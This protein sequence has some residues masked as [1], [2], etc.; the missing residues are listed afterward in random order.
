MVAIIRE[1]KTRKYKIYWYE[2]HNPGN[3]ADRQEGDI[4]EEGIKNIMSD[5][6]PESKWNYDGDDGWIE[7]QAVDTF[8]ARDIIEAK[9][10]A[11][12]Y[13]CGE[14]NIFTVYDEYGNRLFTEEDLER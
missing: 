9:K 11:M 12:G 8:E 5:F 2:Y 7:V 10:K 6:S 1:R 13:E 3:W 4:E 14:S